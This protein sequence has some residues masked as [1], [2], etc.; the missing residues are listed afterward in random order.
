MFSQ[1]TYP[2]Y[3]ERILDILLYLK[4]QYKIKDSSS[5]TYRYLKSIDNM[6]LRRV[7]RNSNDR[8]QTLVSVIKTISR[9]D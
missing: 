2:T 9:I 7:K 8:S 4:E 6:I 3:I 5:N 1:L